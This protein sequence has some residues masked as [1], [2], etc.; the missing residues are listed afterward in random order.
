MTLEYSHS[1]ALDA[2]VGVCSCEFLGQHTHTTIHTTLNT[3]AN[4]YAKLFTF[5]PVFFYT[6]LSTTRPIHAH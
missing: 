6:Y 5:S 1:L 2:Y 4:T 3:M